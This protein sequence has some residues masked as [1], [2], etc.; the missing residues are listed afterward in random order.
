MTI[1]ILLA[2]D[3]ANMR[4]SLRAL[5]DSQPG[6]MVVGEADNGRTML[7]LTGLSKP[8]VVVMDIKIPDLNSTDAVRQIISDTPGVK[9]LVLSMYSN[10]EFAEGMLKAGA[11]GYLLKDH[12]F[13]ELVR[14]IQTVADDC[15]YLC[16][17]IE[18]QAAP[19]SG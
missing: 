2:D 3:H 17:G 16:P 18:D 5:I 14:A 12:A 19:E 15:I 1:R 11:L 6:M 10:P 9:L 13:E 4:H 8:D 7:Q